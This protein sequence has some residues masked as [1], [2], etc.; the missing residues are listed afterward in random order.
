MFI[1]CSFIVLMAVLGQ[2]NPHSNDAKCKNVLNILDNGLQTLYGIIIGDDTRGQLV[3]D[4][5]VNAS[6]VNDKDSALLWAYNDLISPIGQAAVRNSL[7]QDVCMPLID[8][9]DDSAYDATQAL[10]HHLQSLPKLPTNSAWTWQSCRELG[11]FQTTHP[12]SSQPFQQ[13]VELDV[14]Y[15]SGKACTGD[16]LKDDSMPSTDQIYRTY[17]GLQ[18]KSTV[19]NITFIQGCNDPW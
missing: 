6:Q 13:F 18:I 14:Q 16:F 2:I 11:Y 3:E 4:F 1:H 9:Y 15:L 8:A 5:G 7:T 12:A 17:G 10:Y 19:S